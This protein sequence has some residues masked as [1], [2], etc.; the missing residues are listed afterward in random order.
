LPQNQLL[1]FVARFT[2]NVTK[3]PG[4]NITQADLECH[5]FF[6]VYFGSGVRMFWADKKNPGWLRSAVITHPG[7]KYGDQVDSGTAQQVSRGKFTRGFLL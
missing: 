1:L 4:S 5:T 2:L 6:L 3:K 7:L